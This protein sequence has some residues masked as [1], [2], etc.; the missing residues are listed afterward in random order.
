MTNAGSGDMGANDTSKC[1]YDFSSTPTST[2]H[3]HGLSIN[4][5]Y[6]GD[7]TLGD[8]PSH[9]GIDLH[10]LNATS[11]T[12]YRSP[13][14]QTFIF[15]TRTQP[16]NDPVLRG[17]CEIARLTADQ[18]NKITPLPTEYGNDTDNIPEMGLGNY[19][20]WVVSLV[21]LMSIPDLILAY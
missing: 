16:L 2:A 10:E 3:Q 4:L 20:D 11:C 13:D 9:M 18:V 17:W 19:Q 21:V 12:I 7:A 14:D 5:Y 6:R 8:S 15:D 1:Y